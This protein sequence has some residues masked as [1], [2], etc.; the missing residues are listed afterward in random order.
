MSLLD[1]LQNSNDYQELGIDITKDIT[2]DLMNIF[3]E[4]GVYEYGL[5]QAQANFDNI[6]V[7]AIGNVKKLT[8]ARMA[9]SFIG[10]QF[11]IFIDSDFYFGTP[12]DVR[13]VAM[14]HD[15]VHIASKTLDNRIVYGNVDKNNRGFREGATQFIAEDATGIK[16]SDEY[17]TY[18][19]ARNI[20]T[21]VDLLIGNNKVYKD[22]ICHTDYLKEDLEEVSNKNYYY[23]S[24]LKDI[25]ML[26]NLYQFAHHYANE[27]TSN[28]IHMTI[29]KEN[30]ANAIYLHKRNVFL[31][32]FTTC[33]IFPKFYLKSRAE[34]QEFIEKLIDIFGKE[35]E[36]FKLIHA[37]LKRCF[38]G[39]FNLEQY[40]EKDKFVNSHIESF[41]KIAG[42]VGFREVF[43]TKDG[44]VYLAKHR[45]SDFDLEEEILAYLYFTDHSSDEIENIIQNWVNDY[46]R[47]HIVVKLPDDIKEA[48]KAMAALNQIAKEHGYKLFDNFDNIYS[49]ATMFTPTKYECVH[50]LIK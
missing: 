10:G 32:K 3:K 41:E 26:A 36:E 35:S 9:T 29:G 16:L 21:I 30:L 8:A 13:K 22:M 28:Q 47:E 34:R 40:N 4:K 44:R 7:I 19:L 23:S 2:E 18:P 37:G 25:N 48:K 46:N 45:V 31:K 50:R 20:A 38:D 11:Y 33:Y 49:G 42:I 12:S 27:Y 17:C 6:K 14:Y 24:F 39:N 15:L 5:N 43:V 1:R